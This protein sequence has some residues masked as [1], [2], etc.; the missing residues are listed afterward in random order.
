MPRGGKRPGAGRT[1]TKLSTT[2]KLKKATA[3]EILAKV[4]ET[5]VWADLLNAMTVIPMKDAPALNVP[6]R[7][8]RFD[9]MKYLTDRRDGKAPQSVDMNHKGGITLIHSVPRPERTA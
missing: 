6:D 9:V 2:G 5:A 8:L 7:R 3:E 1:K 4:D